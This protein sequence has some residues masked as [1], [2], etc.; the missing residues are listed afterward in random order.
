MIRTERLLLRPFRSDDLA[1]LH[2]IFSDPR[3]MRYWERPA[4]QDIDIT[5]A[6]LAR[7]MRVAPDEHLEYAIEI[8]G[9]CVGRAAMWRRY[10]LSYILHPDHWGQGI[11]TEAVTALIG[12]IRTRF[13]EAPALTAEIDPR[14]TG[15]RRL[16]EKV[17]FVQTGYAEKNFDYGG[18]EM[19]D[20]AY[21]SCPLLGPDPKTPR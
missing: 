12:D 4:W 17:G 10:E 16:L 14:N 2:R 19:T 3:A 15:S 11:A 9:Q 5:R 1:A 8:A 13:A 7:F 18:I 21:F 20:T 6:L